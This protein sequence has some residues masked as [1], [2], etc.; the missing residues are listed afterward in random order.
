MLRTILISCFLISSI[1]C[2]N[3]E[4]VE[5]SINDNILTIQKK[6]NNDNNRYEY[7]EAGMMYFAPEYLVID[8]GETVE[9]INVGGTHDVDGTTNN[10]TGEPWNNPEDF[11]LSSVSVGD[12]EDPVSMGWFTFDTPGVY[13]Y[14]CGLYSHA[15]SGMVGTII[16]NAVSNTCDDDTA[17]NFG[18]EG[19]CQ[20]ANIG[21]GGV[22]DCDGNIFDCSGECGGADLT[23]TI[24]K[25]NDLGVY[26]N[27]DCTGE[28]TS[29]S[30]GM[31]MI[32]IDG[33]M[34]I[35]FL[36]EAQCI[37]SGGIFL[38][39]DACHGM[40]MNMDIF[41]Q[42]ACDEIGG[43]W[44]ETFDDYGNLEMA[45]CIEITVIDNIDNE[46]DCENNDDYMASFWLP[47]MANI[48]LF[49][50]YEDSTFSLST[51]DQCVWTDNFPTEDDCLMYGGDWD[52][53]DDLGEQ[54]D[55]DDSAN[56]LILDGWWLE[57]GLIEAGT[58]A[59][60]NG[61]FFID[62]NALSGAPDQFVGADLVMDEEGN[63][64]SLDLRFLDYI[65]PD[66]LECAQWGLVNIDSSLDN[67]EINIPSDISI[68]S[69]YP[70]P[71]NPITTI[72]FS[73]SS[74]SSIV[75]NLYDINGHLIQNI[76][77]GYYGAGNYSE[78]IDA[79]NLTSGSYFVRL[80]SDNYSITEKLMLIK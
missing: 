78:I 55:I 32:V 53:D 54:C 7:V 4:N 45:M 61:G 1:F 67:T 6:I 51:G 11:Y 68:D 8:V 60:E 13:N 24:M 22:C 15:A 72:D 34:D 26:E 73:V 57:A 21:P 43:L 17:C 36:D 76:T 70:N 79:T 40:D 48:Q 29:V 71:F 64:L 63:W 38:S 41:N 19:E 25:G 74:S 2:F 69:I 23:C 3:M 49:Y 62:P 5:N 35:S 37:A 47:N 30:D 39:T 33:D 50:F 9:W 12:G 58:W 52:S 10:V 16:V 59:Y 77:E 46:Y 75:I 44:L 18:E 20:Y 80:E 56:C 27:D 14:D 66:E 42:D 31:C 28:F 65:N